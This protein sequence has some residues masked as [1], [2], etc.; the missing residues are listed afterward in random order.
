MKQLWLGQ[1][2]VPK[3]KVM[4]KIKCRNLLL[5]PSAPLAPLE[6]PWKAKTQ[7]MS[8]AMMLLSQPLMNL[9]QVSVRW[10]QEVSPHDRWLSCSSACWRLFLTLH[11]QSR[12]G[13]ARG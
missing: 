1:C 9:L 4:A 10:K 3:H 8:Q 5:H 13:K 7:G 12:A 2:G 11:F 6:M